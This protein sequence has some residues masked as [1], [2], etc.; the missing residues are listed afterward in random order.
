MA[1]TSEITIGGLLDET[2][3]RF[4]HN[5]A[6]VDLPASS[7]F[8]YKEFAEHVNSLAK[9]FIKL[10]LQEGEQ[11][12]LWAPNRWEWIA[13]QFAAA[14]VGVVLTSV[15][16]NYRAEQLEYQLKQSDCKTL[17]MSPGI[18]GD[19][20][21]EIFTALCPPTGKHVAGQA[22]YPK[23]PELERVILISNRR[24]PG[25]LRWGDVLEMGREVADEELLDRQASVKP[26]DVAVLLYT[27]G[28]TGVPK[29]VMCTHHSVI[30]VSQATADNQRLH[31]KDRLC[32]SVPLS[33][34]FGCIVVVLT[35]VCKGASIVIP[36][37]GF[38][39]TLALKAIAREECTAFYGAPSSWVALMEHPDFRSY[40]PESLR[41]G[42]MAGAPCPVEVMRKVVE[43]LGAGETIIGY[44]QTEASS[45]I[46]ETRPDDP[47]ELR[48][49]TVGRPLPNIE[50]KILDPSSGAEVAAGEIGELC[51]RGFNM[52]GYYK[53]PA[54]T[55]RALDDAGW[56]HTGDLATMGRDGYVRITGRLKD[57]IEKQDGSIF[58]TEIE[59]ILYTHPKVLNAQAFGIPRDDGY[60]DVV[61]WVQ[62]K[63]KESM[64]IDELLEYCRSNLPSSHVPAHIEFVSEFPTTPLG[65]I[66]KY[67]MRE[68]HM[69]SLRRD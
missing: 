47:L 51:A 30:A 36:S 2:T 45:F 63:E 49:S 22:N 25:M 46:T 48:V 27:S 44:G 38:D 12:A 33:H 20:F 35:G 66:Q 10:G 56:L 29:G 39:P 5:E 18:E 68:M 67:K 58:P 52:K 61:L 42:I 64:T 6:I 43:D 8:T 19:E 69:A 62:L 32:L 65:K 17:V 9:G 41:T 60:E 15:D 59:E 1:R 28:T 37:P 50:V 53:M 21:L 26:E 7:I 4:P 13:T 31:A 24:E 3:A 23:F 14:K 34:M 16:V 57:T 40:R 54:A 11:L 55:K